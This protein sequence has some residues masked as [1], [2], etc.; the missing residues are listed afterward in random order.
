MLL[1]LVPA[2]I[3]N[4]ASAHT[5]VNDACRY[6]VV[7]NGKRRLYVP[8]STFLTREFMVVDD[9]EAR[10][11]HQELSSSA[12]AASSAGLPYSHAYVHGPDGHP[13]WMGGA[14][15]DPYYMNG[16]QAHNMLFMP[17]HVHGTFIPWQHAA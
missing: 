6:T 3:C 9:P 17:G 8:N 1:L 13:R 7:R 11:R 10:S 16:R 4:M 15:Y 12:L 14:P 2:I 5:F